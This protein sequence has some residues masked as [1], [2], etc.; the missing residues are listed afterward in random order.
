M[1]ASIPNAASQ[2]PDLT[3]KSLSPVVQ[4]YLQT[5]SSGQRPLSKAQAEELARSEHAGKFVQYMTS[6]ASSA[7]NPSP[8]IDLRYPLSNYYINSSHNTYL[9]GN[10][11][12]SE[13]SADAYT[14]VCL[15]VL[16]SKSSKFNLCI[17]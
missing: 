17:Y 5:I 13:S 11:L 1:A 9:T 2:Q 3:I 7:A 14:N 4:S 16:A 10:Q 15:Q 6:L 12:Y 8:P